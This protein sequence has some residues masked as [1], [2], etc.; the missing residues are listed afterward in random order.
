MQRSL[1]TFP[2]DPEGPAPI[3]VAHCST[4]GEEILE[5]D[6]ARQGPDGELYCSESCAAEAL[7]SEVIARPD[8]NHGA[9]ASGP[10]YTYDEAYQRAQRHDR[11]C[12]RARWLVT[13]WRNVAAGLREDG[14]ADTARVYER[15]ARQLQEV[16]Q[17]KLPAIET[18]EAGNGS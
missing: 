10:L 1:N 8:G 13:Y 3:V 5:D 4:C 6:Y 14:R 9:S 17:D 18:G 7:T 15:C 12:E 16:L 11:F 2:F